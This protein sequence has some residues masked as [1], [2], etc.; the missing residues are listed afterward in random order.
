VERA[1]QLNFLVGVHCDAIQGYIFA[2][3]VS[4]QDA[5]ERIASLDC[6]PSGLVNL[7]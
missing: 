2:P 5:P 6:S 7:V 4:A 1:D 3:P